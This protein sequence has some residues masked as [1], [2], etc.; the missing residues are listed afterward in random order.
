MASKKVP[1]KAIKPDWMTDHA[2]T[3]I[4][5]AWENGLSDR[6]AS[7]R[8]SRDGEVYITE[9]EL[10]ELV[11]SDPR[12]AD[13]RDF[14]HTDIVAQAK[15]NIAE[16]LREGSVATAKWY[17][18]RKASDEFSSKASVAFDATVVEVSME[19]KQKKLEE[20]LENFISGTEEDTEGD[21]GT[22]GQVQGS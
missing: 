17:L 19:D 9:T 20:A 1:Y 10:K 7:F 4:I 5:T 2:W 3:E 6:E 14:L 21:N 16:S 13:I 8:A 15:L 22:E 12:I 18:E 11:A